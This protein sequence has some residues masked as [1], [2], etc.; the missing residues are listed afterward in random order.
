MDRIAVITGGGRGIGRAFALALAQTGARIVVTGR[1][2]KP[3]EET[4][5]QIGN[6]TLAIACDVASPSSVERAFAEIHAKCGRVDVLVN[7]AGV[8]SAIE[9]LWNVDPDLW[10]REIEINLRGCF[11]CARAVLPGMVERRSGR[12]IHIASHAGVFRWPYCSA[13]SVGKAALIKLSENLAFESR[14]FNVA[15]FAF[16]PG[17]VKGGFADNLSETPPPEGTP[18]RKVW[19]WVRAELASPRAVTP[20]QSAAGVVKLASGTCDAL[21]GRYLTVH[22]D[23]DAL[24]ANAQ[25]IQSEDAL[26]LR[27]KE[28]TQ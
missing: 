24:A 2:P 20:E 3:L 23:L 18:G 28:L 1:N 16:H 6:N 11:L 4:A 14:K 22:D 27:L 25:Q 21:T 19:D 13:Y 15:S 26:T 9:T 5:K 10:W 12:L 7:N 17:F 8:N